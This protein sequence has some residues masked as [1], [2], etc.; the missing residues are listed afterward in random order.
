MARKQ[1][2]NEQAVSMDSLMDALTN[3]VAVLI[4]ILILLQLDVE[5]AATRLIKEL[6][7][8]SEE[9]IALAK[10]QKETLAGQISK[11]K[12]LLDAPKPSPQALSKMNADISLLEKSLASHQVELMEVDKLKIRLDGEK[13]IEAKESKITEN[14]LSEISRIKS[15]L[16]DTPVPKAPQATVIKIPTSRE[17]PESAQILYCYIFKDQIHF[18]DAVQAKKSVLDELKRQD[19]KLLLEVRKIK[20]KP[21]IRIYDQEKTVSYFQERGLKARNHLIKIPYNKAYGS[22]SIQINFDASKGEATLADLEQKSGRF[23]NLCRYVRSVPRSVLIFRVH[24][25]GFATYLK[26]REITDSMKIPCGWEVAFNPQHYEYVGIPVNKLEN[27][28]KDT[29]APAPQIKR[30]LD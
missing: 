26:A 17:I 25:E 16:D 18:I 7:P 30:T 20:N 14:I 19:R 15:L 9:Q 5:Q 12:N 8:A 27:A 29:K 10:K 22:L 23:H 2:N 21:D 4:V 13:L 24:P 6:L 11:Q 1:S 28:P 3:V